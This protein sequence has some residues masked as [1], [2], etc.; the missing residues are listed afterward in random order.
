MRSIVKA[1]YDTWLRRARAPIA[2]I[3]I[4]VL[5]ACGGDDAPSPPTNAGPPGGIVLQVV[6]FGDSLS[7]VGTYGWYAEPNFG[8]D[9]FT[10]NPGQV[11]AQSVATYYGGSLTPARNGGFTLTGETDAGGL[12][13]AEGGARATLQP[14]LGAPALSAT[15][16]DTQIANYL[17][18]YKRFNSNQLVLIDGGTS[19]LWV[20]IN[21]F[22]KNGN[23]ASFIGQAVAAVQGAANALAAA[24]DTVVQNGA[25][26][27][28]LVNAPDLG[29][30][31]AGLSLG[32]GYYSSFL[33][34]LSNLFNMT[35]TQ[36]LSNAGISN[37][38][39]YVDAYTFIDNLLASNNAA[40]VG[41]TV[42]NTG[43]ACNVARM[44]AA[45]TAYGQAN[46]SALNGMTPAAFGASIASS[47][48][49]TPAMYTVAGADQTYMFAD[50]LH[51]STKLHALLTQYVEQ[52]IAASGIG[53]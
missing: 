32:G 4:A 47:L 1:R 39:I 41:F 23:N 52:R 17:I 49:C 53:R 31:P 25:T 8:G 10:T 27:V 42:T 13:F 30:M 11:W 6:S 14:G 43:T 50:G 20:A 46:A 15:P 7:D 16:I 51:P 40:A 22:I 18:Q 44:Q 34:Q 29:A 48:F 2:A 35:L 28:V 33:S 26:Q 3:A 38:V 37:K 36:A 45:A 24:V 19:D 12:G 5:T 9:Q 21:T